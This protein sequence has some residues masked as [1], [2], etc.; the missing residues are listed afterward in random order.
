MICDSFSSVTCS[1]NDEDIS[2]NVDQQPKE[3]TVVTHR[4]LSISMEMH[5]SPASPQKFRQLFTCAR[6]EG[7]GDEKVDGKTMTRHLC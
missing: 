5:S 4:L 2:E 7:V 6:L 3:Q 1:G